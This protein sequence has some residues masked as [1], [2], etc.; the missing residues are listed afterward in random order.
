M[1]LFAWA[2]A[3]ATL[4]S[5]CGD[6]NLRNLRSLGEGPDEFAVVPNKP[7]QEPESYSALPP[8]TPGGFNR[9]DQRPLEDGIAALGGRA[10]SPSAPI[11]GS[12]TALVN[13]TSRFGREGNIRATLAQADQEFRD[14]Q[15]RLTNIRIFREDLYAQIYRRESLN[16]TAVATQF[17]RAGIPTPSAPPGGRRR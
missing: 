5:A 11:P 1:R 9:T 8:P 16:P 17:R 13:H 15:R 6:T 7:L 4:V 10:T 12:D 3:A 14:R 2:L